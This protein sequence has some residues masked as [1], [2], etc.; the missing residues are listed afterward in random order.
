[1]WSDM[2]M[3]NGEIKE[4][5]DTNPAE[6]AAVSVSFVPLVLYITENGMVFRQR[7]SVMIFLTLSAV[8]K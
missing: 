7:M 3:L 4:Y 1:M 8:T 2:Y 5:W 6:D